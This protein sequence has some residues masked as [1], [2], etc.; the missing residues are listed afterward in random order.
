MSW[1]K[2]GAEW[3]GVGVMV[4]LCCY[5]CSHCNESEARARKMNAETK[6]IEQQIESPKPER[7]GQ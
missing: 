3:I 6:L 7:P 5:G 1:L 4:L 2:D